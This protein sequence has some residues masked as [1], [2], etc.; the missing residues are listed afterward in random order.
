[1][2]TP[3]ESLVPAAAPVPSAEPVPVAAPLL[4][5]GSQ[6]RF[7]ARFIAVYGALSVVLV[8][9]VGA[10]VVFAIQGTSPGWSSWKPAQGTQKQLTREIADHVSSQYRFGGGGLLVAIVPGVGQPSVSIGTKAIGIT[11]IA[12]RTV[13]GANANVAVSPTDNT[14]SYSF[15]GLGTRCA[16]S[17]GTPSLTRGQVVRREVLETALYTFKYM[18]KVD[19]V[20]AYMPTVTGANFVSLLYLRKQDL[21]TQ[22]SHPL[23]DTLKLSHPPLPTQS[24]VVEGP[25]IDGLTLPRLFQYSFTDL[26]TNGAL[27]ILSPIA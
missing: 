19:S 24:N 17:S 18:P 25:L 16:I 4:Q 15:C 26:Q 21:K 5:L 8:A 1:M 3:S 23:K 27:L 10:I 6:K 9:S 22:L 12:S 14:V 11:A 13:A 2:E 20:I 7:T